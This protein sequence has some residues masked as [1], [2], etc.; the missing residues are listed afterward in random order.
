MYCLLTQIWLCNWSSLGWF[1][2][3][4]EKYF[5]NHFIEVKQ[6][7]RHVIQISQKT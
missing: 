1:D 5:H 7:E 4:S 6:I 2:N 3:E